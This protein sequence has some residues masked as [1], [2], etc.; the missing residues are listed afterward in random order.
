MIGVWSTP[1][2]GYSVVIGVV[3][4][5]L[6]RMTVVVMYSLQQPWT[7]LFLSDDGNLA[8]KRCAFLALQC[9]R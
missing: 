3:G 7:C 8:S 6:S 2:Q 4:S 5:I 1:L 9:R